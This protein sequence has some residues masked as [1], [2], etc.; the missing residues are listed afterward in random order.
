MAQ[1]GIAHYF[2]REA[3][4]GED[5]H[6]DATAW[7]QVFIDWQLDV[8]RVLVIE[9]N[10]RSLRDLA[11]LGFK[12]LVWLDEGSGWSMYR[13]GEVPSGLMVVKSLRELLHPWRIKV[14][15]REKGA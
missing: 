11:R 8:A 12:H 13:E 14:P 9:D 4:I 6:K 5:G 3:I 1:S 7:G 10:L 15:T 2:R